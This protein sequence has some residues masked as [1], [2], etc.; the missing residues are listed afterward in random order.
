ME[1]G[2]RDSFILNALYMIIDYVCE[3]TGDGECVRMAFRD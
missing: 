3:G 2:D 1:L